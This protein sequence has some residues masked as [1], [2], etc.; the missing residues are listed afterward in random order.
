MTIGLSLQ[1]KAWI[2]KFLTE[3]KQAI[4][5]FQDDSFILAQAMLSFQQGDYKKVLQYLNKE[6]A[7]G[8]PQLAKDYDTHI[9][10]ADGIIISF[11]EHNGSYT[12]AF[13]NIHDWWSRIDR[14][15]FDNKPLFSLPYTLQEVDKTA[16][17]FFMRALIGVVIMR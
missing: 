8:I 10:S 14:E 3:K 17:I 9:K 2:S 6:Q 5:D 1:N 16:G 13:K 7:D 12:S 15:R 4:E 11:A